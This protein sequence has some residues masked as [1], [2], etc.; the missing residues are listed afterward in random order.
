MKEALPLMFQTG[1]LTFTS[2]DEI[3]EIYTL[4][5]PNREVERTLNEMLL[6]VYIENNQN[7]GGV[8]MVNKLRLA[9]ANEKLDEVKN[10]IN[11]LFKTLPYTLWQNENEAFF[12]AILHLTFKLLGIY[13][14]SEVLT[15]DGRIDSIIH[16]AD[17]IY[18]I[19]IKLDKSAQEALQQIHDKGYLVAY[20]HVDKKRIAIG[21]NFSKDKKEVAELEWE[22]Y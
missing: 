1:Y 20:E 15:S 2:Y 17:K 3:G 5:F 11:S 8:V 9:L 12:H 22:L 6:D 14:Q 18:C 19:E 10:I 21:I 16:F 7:V 13:V 4:N